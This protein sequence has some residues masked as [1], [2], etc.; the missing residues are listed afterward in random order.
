MLSMY[1]C[2]Y[3][4]RKH[5]KTLALSISDYIKDLKMNII[6]TILISTS[7]ILQPT[8]IDTLLLPIL[9][10][11]KAIAVIIKDSHN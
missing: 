7:Y 10:R 4:T 2:V 3:Y 9:L 11:T 6:K 5:Y 1:L 8:D